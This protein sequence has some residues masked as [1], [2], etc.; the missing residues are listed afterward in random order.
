MANMSANDRRATKMSQTGPKPSKQD[1]PR[2]ATLTKD[3]ARS[4]MA[5]QVTGSSTCKIDPSKHTKY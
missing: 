5:S 2:V 4:D 1:A 3:K